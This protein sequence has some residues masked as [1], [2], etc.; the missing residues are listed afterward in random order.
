MKKRK[1]INFYNWPVL[2]I[3]GLFLYVIFYYIAAQYYPGGSNF[4]PSQKG[5]DLF[6]NYWCELLGRNAK[7]GQPNEARPIGMTGMVILSITLSNFWFNFPKVIPINQLMDRTLRLSGILAMFCSIFIFSH[8]HDIFIYLGVAFGT[9]T[10][11][12][13]LY[14]QYRNN[15]KGFFLLCLLCYILILINN[16]IYLSDFLIIYLPLIQKFTFALIF[17]WIFL[18]CIRFIK[19]QEVPEIQEN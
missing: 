15:L 9:I 18:I 8:Y 14:G 12:L 7:N 19:E 5:F 13:S 6:N 2:T 1:Y 16:L 11:V 4:D 10:F 3:C 17:I